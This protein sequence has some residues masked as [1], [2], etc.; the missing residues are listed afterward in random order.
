[1][2]FD[3]VAGLQATVFI[4][5]DFGA[6]RRGLGGRQFARI[7]KAAVCCCGEFATFVLG[8][9]V[10]VGYYRDSFLMQPVPS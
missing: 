8:I 7:F 10:E 9:L 6:E 4:R 1:V 5:A 3:S 2:Q